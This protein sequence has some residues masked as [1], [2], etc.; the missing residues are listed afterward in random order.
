[1][2]SF[3]LMDAS[4]MGFYLLLSLYLCPHPLTVEISVC[5]FSIACKHGDWGYGQCKCTILAQ[6][7][8]GA[9]GKRKSRGGKESFTLPLVEYSVWGDAW[10]VCF[11]YYEQKYSILYVW[12]NKISD[13]CGCFVCLAVVFPLLTV[14]EWVVARF[15]I[16]S[17]RSSALQIHP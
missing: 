2:E 5:T 14:S 12:E 7:I 16:C 9:E 6:W 4:G 10:E 3:G 13:C 1:M 15:Y 17:R 8:G 11:M